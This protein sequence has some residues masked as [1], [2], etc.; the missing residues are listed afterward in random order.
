MNDDDSIQPRPVVEDPSWFCPAVE[1]VIPH[2]L[3]WEY[4]F[5]GML[6]PTDTRDELLTWIHR[7]QRF[8]SLDDF[9]TIC[10]TCAHC[11]WSR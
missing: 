11:Q 2:S 10:E 7:S 4:C 3:C 5:A 6:G 1:C 8:A 9:H